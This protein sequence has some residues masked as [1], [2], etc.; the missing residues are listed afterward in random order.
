MK[1]PFDGNWAICQSD[2]YDNQRSRNAPGSAKLQTWCTFEDAW[3]ISSLR[4][5]T[6]LAEQII[7]RASAT[8]YWETWYTSSGGME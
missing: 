2:V 3:E 6:I 4:N 7:N 8:C 5:G 1:E